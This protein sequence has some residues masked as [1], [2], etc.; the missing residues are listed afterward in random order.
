MINVV[1]AYLLSTRPIFQSDVIGVKPQCC[2]PTTGDLQ[3]GESPRPRYIMH[4]P[5]ASAP[6]CKLSLSSSL[7]LSIQSRMVQF[8]RK[9][10]FT[11]AARSASQT[12][13]LFVPQCGRSLTQCKNGTPSGTWTLSTLSIYTTKHIA[14]TLQ[15]TL[16]VKPGSAQ[17]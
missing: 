16:L 13:R 7:Q 10:S 8:V 6:T 3:F 12:S 14:G 9:L 17:V 2:C 11:T 15:Q 4:N 5:H 1:C